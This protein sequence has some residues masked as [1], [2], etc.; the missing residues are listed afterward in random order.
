MPEARV[1]GY[2]QPSVD[3]TLNLLGIRVWEKSCVLIGRRGLDW[4]PLGR[5]RQ[6]PLTLPVK[7]SEILEADELL[8]TAY[9]MQL[10]FPEWG[11]GEVLAQKRP[12]AAALEVCTSC[13]VPC[14]R[15]DHKPQQRA[16]QEFSSHA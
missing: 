12:F 7:P 8:M 15:F 11:I 1:S 13:A 9:Q 16:Y 2:I 3:F 5:P 6:L 4:R 14:C 10:E